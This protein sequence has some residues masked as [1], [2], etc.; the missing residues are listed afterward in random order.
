[1]SSAMP[2]IAAVPQKLA[3]GAQASPESGNNN[4][5]TQL[6]SGYQENDK[7]AGSSAEIS[8]A[9][10]AAQALTGQGSALPSEGKLLPQ[11]ILAAS[12]EGVEVTI[13]EL[14]SGTLQEDQS[15]QEARIGTGQLYSSDQDPLGL[16]INDLT[17]PLPGSTPLVS[18]L[19][20][21]PLTSSPLAPATVGRVTADS[22]IQTVQ[23]TSLKDPDAAMI[24]LG[25]A[26][27]QSGGE[28]GRK[29]NFLQNMQEMRLTSL[30]QLGDTSNQVL[31]ANREAVTSIMNATTTTAAA[32][33]EAARPATM[34]TL[35][36]DGQLNRPE[37]RDE[38]ASRV[39]W[40]VRNDQSAARLRINPAHL[41]PMEISIKMSQDQASV[42]FVSQ[43]I[44]VREA[45]ELAI[46]RL[47]EML[48]QQGLNLA[49]VDISSGYSPA[50]QPGSDAADEAGVSDSDRALSGSDESE[51]STDKDIM[52]ALAGELE[53]DHSNGILDEYV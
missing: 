23:T 9:V 15:L 29:D 22:P 20:G 39:S 12:G 46:P 50:G 7:Q 25:D 28:Q 13:D 21:Q 14:Q 24:D 5:F 37:W 8:S 30:P 4:D 44:Q 51:T 47:R 38:M 2:P 40:L 26:A 42:S 36:L 49:D 33:P 10:E 52:H 11:N 6:L 18:G 41:G 48:E 1:M 3:A 34:P 19:P 35:S 27:M 17:K 32:V 45:V 43:H 31:S 16:L 53:M